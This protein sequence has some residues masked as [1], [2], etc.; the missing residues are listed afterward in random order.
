MKTENMRQTSQPL[1]DIIRKETRAPS[2]Y[3]F[4]LQDGDA[5]PALHHSAG[6][7]AGY[8]SGNARTRR[9]TYY[10]PAVNELRVGRGWLAREFP[11]TFVMARL[12]G[13]R[14]GVV[15]PFAEPAD[16]E[17]RGWLRERAALAAESADAWARVQ[18]ERAASRTL[19]AEE[20]GR[21]YA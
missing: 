10:T 4:V 7:G 1:E 11:V 8:W 3:K 13:V 12:A 20:D 5:A 15:P 16:L 18:A 17:W 19:D 2:K 14:A 9:Y 21:A 6:H